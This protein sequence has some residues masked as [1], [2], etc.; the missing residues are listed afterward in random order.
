MVA[1]LP[2]GRLTEDKT[3]EFLSSMELGLCEFE[4]ASKNINKKIYTI[5][6]DNYSKPHN[7]K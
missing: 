5:S 2:F 4:V 3:L 1:G 6:Q 7:T